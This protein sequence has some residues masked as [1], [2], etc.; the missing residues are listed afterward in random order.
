[1]KDEKLQISEEANPDT[2]TTNDSTVPEN[3]KRKVR[4]TFE[5]QFS[6]V[7]SAIDLSINDETLKLAAANFGYT[8]EKISGLKYLFDECDRFYEAQ[9]TAQAK[10]L[11]ATRDFV[12]KKNNA[13]K[14]IRH[15]LDT[16]K[17]AFKNAP[18]IC[19]EMGLNKGREKAFGA[20]VAQ[21]K[22]FYTKILLPEHTA[23]MADYQITQTDL[24]AGQRAVMDTIAAEINGENAKAETQKATELKYNSWRRLRLAMRKYLNVMKV[25]LD[26]DPQ[27]KEKL[28]IVTPLLVQ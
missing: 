6:R 21:S 11:I 14:I 9:K 1:M 19:L 13:V 17:L 24:E 2:V 10:Q 20:W 22:Y 28:G 23:Q 18:D 16:A 27:M 12:E 3:K 4:Y 15:H 26:E 7:R 5:M 8:T 25:A